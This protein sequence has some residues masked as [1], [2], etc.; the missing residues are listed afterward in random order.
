MH[1]SSIFIQLT[2]SILSVFA[3]SNYYDFFN[4]TDHNDG[5]GTN[6]DELM[7][8]EWYTRI[9]TDPALAEQTETHKI[10]G[11]YSDDDQTEELQKAEAFRAPNFYRNQTIQSACVP[12]DCE[13]FLNTGTI[14]TNCSFCDSLLQ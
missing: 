4:I 3:L 5:R 1:C 2:T 13:L 14:S 7:L 9:I 11:T 12:N 8:N 6:L 10:N